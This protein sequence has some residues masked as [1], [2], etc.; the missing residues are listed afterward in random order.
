MNNLPFVGFQMKENENVQHI[1]SKLL[2]FILISLMQ[3]VSQYVGRVTNSLKFDTFM[4]P[5]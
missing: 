4:K 2:K 1:L 5:T 3:R